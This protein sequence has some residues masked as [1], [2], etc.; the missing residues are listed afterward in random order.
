MTVVEA[1]ELT[2]QGGANDFARLIPACEVFGPYC[3]IGGLAVNCCVE[4]V[5]T[6]DADFVVVSSSLDIL[7][8]T[9]KTAVSRLKSISTL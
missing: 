1:C 4:P 8:P 5:Y 3:L 6:L 7:K 2:T 9:K